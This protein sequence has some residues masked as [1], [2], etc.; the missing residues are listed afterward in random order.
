M[1]FF[2]NQHIAKLYACFFTRLL[3]GIPQRSLRDHKNIVALS[4][5]VRNGHFLPVTFQSTISPFLNVIDI[6]NHPYHVLIQ[7][8]YRWGI[9][10]I[11]DELYG[12]YRQVTK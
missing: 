8:S 2:I 9:F 12:F 11:C 6:K 3:Q 5:K 7:I 10:Y 1:N 4:D